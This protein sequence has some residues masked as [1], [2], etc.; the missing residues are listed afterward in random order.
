MLARQESIDLDD[1]SGSGPSGRITVA[2]V[3]QAIAERDSG[4]ALADAVSEVVP[5]TGLR[6][7][8]ADRMSMSV[9]TM[10]Q[11]TLTTEVDVTE[12]QKLRESLVS[13]WR[14]HRLRPLDLDIVIA[15]VAD[16][17][18]AHPRLNSHLVDGEVRLLKDVNIGVAVGRPGRP[19]CARPQ[20]RGL[21]EPAGRGPRDA[22]AR[23][24]D[25]ERP[26]RRR[27]HDGRRN[28]P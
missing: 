23:R 15:A 13:D 4:A 11:V 28:S 20:R 25:E 27:R 17:L 2:D 24:Q 9:S 10:A 19:G 7:T 18:K 5:L 21:P 14:P 8:I 22:H 6:K 16:A 12:L 3:E 26:A 1:I